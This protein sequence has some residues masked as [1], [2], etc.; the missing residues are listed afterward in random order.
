MKAHNHLIDYAKTKGL[1][2]R[3]ITISDTDALIIV[4]DN[5]ENL[6]GVAEV[7]TG[8]SKEQRA[9]S[10][11]LLFNPNETVVDWTGDFMDEWRETWR[12]NGSQSAIA[13]S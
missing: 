7:I 13:W 10:T 8:T 12:P 6:K 9:R 4:L 11:D 1:D 2:V 3:E 5:N